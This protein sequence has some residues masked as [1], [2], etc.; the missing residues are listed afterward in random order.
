MKKLRKLAAFLLCAAMILAMG[1]TTFAAGENAQLKVKVNADNTL[2][3][4]TLS[5]YKLFDVTVSGDKYGYTVNETYKDAIA[6]ALN[7][8]PATATSDELYEALAAM[9][10]SQIQKFADDFTTAALTGSLAATKTSGTLTDVADYTFTDL[11]Y[12]YYLVYQTGTEELQSSLVT[13]A[14]ASEEVDL[15]GEAP[16]ITKVADVATVQIGQVVTY[17]VTGTIPDTTGYADY[18]YI[19]HDTLTDG[20]DFV[21]DAQGTAVSGTNLTVSVQIGSG[22][23][24]GQTATLSGD[25]NREMKLDLSSWIRDNQDNKGEDFTVTYYAKVN[26]NAVVATNNSAYLEYGNETGETT[27]TTPVKVDTPTY[28]LDINKTIKGDGDMLA[29]AKFRLYRSE[30]DAKAD[31]PAKAIKVTGGNGSYTV[32]ADQSTGSATDMVS[33]DT[34]VGT[35]YN[36]HLNGLA[37]GDY[38]LVETEAPDGYNK[39]TAPVKV[40]IAKT[41]ATEWTVAKNGTDEADKIIDV[42]N[43]TGTILPGTGGIGTIIF[44]VA[45]AALIIGVAVS[46][47]VSR[48]NE[49]AGGKARRRT[50]RR[51]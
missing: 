7:K 47:A 43:S 2:K 33:V 38:W 25:G 32:A 31:D 17:T 27:T 10:S 11:D 49:A 6:T 34:E 21:S 19:I 1:I 41:T 12:G 20:L 44:T 35:G 29:G 46:F 8:T 40:T 50:A 14:K 42:E 26:S 15:K 48:K 18:Q 51:R 5:V 3:G 16:S 23:A 45:G 28:P 30:N 4:Q 39:I 36:L 24:E 13:V 9:D 22:A 37:A